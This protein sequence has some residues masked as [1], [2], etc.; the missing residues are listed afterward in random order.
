MIAWRTRAYEF[1]N[2]IPAIDLLCG[3]AAVR[4]GIDR[5]D[6]LHE[7]AASWAADENAFRTARAAWLLYA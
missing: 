6:S 1:V 5:G 3:S 2:T 4:D 7:L